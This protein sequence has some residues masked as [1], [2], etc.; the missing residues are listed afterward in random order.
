MQ[1]KLI[2]SQWIYLETMHFFFRKCP[3]C[4]KRSRRKTEATKSRLQNIL[5]VVTKA[6]EK[7][8]AVLTVEKLK[9]LGMS[10]HLFSD[11][12]GQIYYLT[13]ASAKKTHT[14]HNNR[15]STLT[16]FSNYFE[17]KESTTT[18]QEQQQSRPESTT[19]EKEHQQNH[20]QSRPGSTKTKQEHQQKHQQSRP[21]S[22][23]TE[24]VHQQSR[25]GS[26]TTKQEHQQ[27][28]QQSR[29]ESTK[30]EQDHQ[31]NH[32][33]SRPGFTTTEQVRQQSLQQ[34][35]LERSRKNKSRKQ[36]SQN[37]YTVLMKESTAKA[38]RMLSYKP[39]STEPSRQNVY[40]QRR[41]KYEKRCSNFVAFIRIAIMLLL[42][43]VS[44]GMNQSVRTSRY[45][46]H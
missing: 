28:H 5:G 43:L 1:N 25:P 37:S 33:Q 11:N 26:T 32:Q 42:I 38:V 31:Q 23:T 10:G 34:S 22:T 12:I 4:R 24:Q 30:T 6:E 36:R 15:Y 44:I 40:L 39:K 3:Y 9:D 16:M 8:D 18:E 20:Q 2:V 14:C 41:G 21:R 19:T 7:N 35:R 27:N 13:G 29:P 45:T 17:K 46:E